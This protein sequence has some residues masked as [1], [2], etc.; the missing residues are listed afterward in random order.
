[1]HSDTERAPFGQGSYGSRSYSVCGAAVLKASHEIK[2]KACKMA[3]HTLKV[4]E[5]EVNYQNGK[6]FAQSEPDKAFTLQEVSLALWYGWDIP[7][8]M[9]P[10][11]EHTTFYDPPDFNYPYGCHIAEVEID[12]QIGQV[13]LT[14]YVGVSD[15]GVIGNELV[16]EGQLQGAI[17]FGMGEALLEQAIYSEDGRILSATFKEY[18]VPKSTHVPN[19]DLA[20][21]VTPN[22]NTDLGAKGAGEVGTVGAAPAISNAVI[23]AI[24]DLGIQH[25]NMPM[26][27]EKVWRAIQTANS[28][29]DQ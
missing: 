19:I 16:L 20:M 6:F 3:A 21:M 17:A 2:I 11:L 7:P 25:L 23:D 13:E 26:T 15:V 24:A 8:G 22:P 27:P 29:A 12:E 9:E 5:V 18:P 10:T 14:R 1:M 4:P 28:P